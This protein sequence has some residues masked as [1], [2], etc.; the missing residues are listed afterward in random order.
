MSFIIVF[1]PELSCAQFQVHVVS[2][3]F[4]TIMQLQACRLIIAITIHQSRGKKKKEGSL[5][6][7]AS[8]NT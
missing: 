6:H 2:H 3:Q 4:S 5:S 1:G 8:L 7:I